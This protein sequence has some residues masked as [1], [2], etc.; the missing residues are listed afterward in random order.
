MNDSCNS[1]G[2]GCGPGVDAVADTEAPEL[3]PQAAL[4]RFRFAADAGYFADELQAQF[5]ITANVQL[6]ENSDPTTGQSLVA[7][8]L[9]VTPEL[10]DET[11][12]KLQQLIEAAQAGEY[13]GMPGGLDAPAAPVS[14]AAPSNATGDETFQVGDDT[15]TPRPRIPSWL[16][17]LVVC[18]GAVALMISMKQQQQGQAAAEDQAA[19]LTDEQVFLGEMLAVSAE[20]WARTTPDGGRQEVS[21]DESTGTMRYREDTDGDGSFEIDRRIRLE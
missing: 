19:P 18:A 14:A 12:P 8:I 16:F 6:E 10:A 4:A 20:P 1:N 21:L 7:F 15:G 3:G 17:L 5:G 11:I 9:S 2:C 13:D